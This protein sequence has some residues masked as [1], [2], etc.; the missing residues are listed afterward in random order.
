MSCNEL[1]DERTSFG[2]LVRSVA[3]DRSDDLK[4]DFPPANKRLAAVFQEA[5]QPLKNDFVYLNIRCVVCHGSIAILLLEWPQ[6]IS[7]RLEDL[8]LD[9]TTLFRL[10]RQSDRTD[11]AD[12]APRHQPTGSALFDVG[13]SASK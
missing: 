1:N 2:D 8:E 13:S 10:E 12:W 5:L 6:G 11:L 4:G 9:R 7:Q 3:A